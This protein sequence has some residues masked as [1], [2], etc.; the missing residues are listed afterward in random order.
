MLFTNGLYEDD[1]FA[2]EALAEIH[3]HGY[4]DA[5]C[6]GRPRNVQEL[7]DIIASLDGEIVTRL[8]ASILGYAY[9]VPSVGLVWNRKQT[10]FGE[11]IRHPERFV[12]YDRFDAPF[13]ADRIE[14]AMS[15][16]YEPGHKERYAS[17]TSRYI[18]QFL[19]SC[20]KT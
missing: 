1:A 2:R 5:V 10:M 18:E 11:A 16:G 8:H 15:E 14:A 4:K 19:L 20:V 6:L 9:H 13:L 12:T 17:L 7:V 3:R